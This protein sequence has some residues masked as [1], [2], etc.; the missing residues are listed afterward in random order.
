[1]GHYQLAKVAIEV[2]SEET[3]RPRNE[4]NRLVG[5]AAMGVGRARK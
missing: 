4:K 2:D 5:L 3:A 1:M